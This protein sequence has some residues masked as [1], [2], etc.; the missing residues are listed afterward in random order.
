MSQL[1]NE[2]ARIEVSNE[3]LL[4]LEVENIYRD[5]S[6][7]Y[8][9]LD[10]LKNF[11]SDY[12][13]KNRLMRWWHNDKLRDAHLDSAEVQAE[14][15]KTIGQLM[16][17]SIMQSKKLTE[18]Q[19]QLNSQQKDLKKQADGIE[20]HAGTLQQQHKVLAE[21]SE[22]LE[23]LVKEYFDLKGLTE[24]GAQKLIEIAK[25]IKGTKNDMLQQ[26]AE[27][28]QN[29]E[30]LHGDTMSR[31]ASLSTELNDR[32]TSFEK[33]TRSEL[34][35]LAQENQQMILVSE[36]SLRAEHE[37]TKADFH[38]SLSPLR[39][40]LQAS[41]ANQHKQEQAY[42]QKIGSIED[43]L[44][45]QAS[46]ISDTAKELFALKTELA[47]YAQRQTNDQETAARL[48]KE[49]S[50]RI[51]KLTVIVGCTA[52]AMLALMGATVHL[53]NWF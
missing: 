9:K 14:F 27:R 16:M 31:M 36:S 8:R 4:Q 50:D 39:Q 23:T 7:N 53:L 11:R 6:S 48:L 22:K 38:Q 12:E 32:L 20:E 17:I 29:L 45:A 42:T 21:Q 2:L 10:D 44:N 5:F 47:G 25:E 49:S 24:D 18:Q 3:A 43:G 13:K 37:A 26:F 19:S 35:V 1:I 15:S 34:T 33:Q 30:A 40:D 46:K 41:V 28:T 52:L 51:G